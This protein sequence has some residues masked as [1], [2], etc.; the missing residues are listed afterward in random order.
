MKDCTCLYNLH[1]H[2][3]QS[4]KPVNEKSFSYISNNNTL[5]FPTVKLLETYRTF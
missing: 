5:S 1:R 3:N 2:D 4:N